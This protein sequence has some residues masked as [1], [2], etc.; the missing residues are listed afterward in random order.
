MSAKTPFWWGILRLSKQQS[1]EQ[2]GISEMNVTSTRAVIVEAGGTQVVGHVG[3][4]AL[5]AFADRVGV[6]E[7]LSVAVGWDGP[8]IP[9]HDRGRVLSQ[10]MLMLAGGGESCADIEALASQG[11]LF[12]DVCS[13]TTLYRTFPRALDEAALV[14]A[15]RAMAQVRT[16][17]WRRT[18]AT[19]GDGPVILDID[20]S[21]VEI[22]SE[23][24]EGAA[25]HFK[26]GYGFHPVFCFAD[27]T[28]DVLAGHLR[29][30][31]AAA[32]DTSDLLAVV[33]DGVDQLPTDVAAGHRPGD[34]PGL[35]QRQVVVRSD[36]A[37]GT[38]VFVEG[39]RGRNI[40][41]AVVARRQ[42]AV[43]AAIMIANSD[44]QRWEA[45]LKQNG[46]QTDTTSDGR[47][48][49]VCEVTD[50]VD[51]GGW[52]DG[53]RLIIRRQP[54]HPGAQTTLL[55]DLEY[56]FWGHYTDQAGDPVD[57]DRQMRAHARVEDHIQRLKDSGLE[58]FPFTEWAPNQ[59]WLQ[60]VCWAADLVR[61]FQLLC[62][63]GPLTRARPKRLRWTL[64]HAPARIITTARRDIVRILDGWPTAGDIV[65]AYRN[66]AALT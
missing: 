19:D 53:T 62:L 55:P 46:E 12:G 16:Q 28:G 5:G 9:V 38:K 52:P 66:I 22:H 56:R 35:V 39:L 34:D 18:S 10:A 63:T 42:A 32:N 20:A 48:A 3:L 2:K 26:G 13:D 58:R 61:W 60:T 1:R 11:R 24:K 6:T 29:A 59:A 50:L 45:A 4:H 8:G 7:S 47:T 21:L 37:G 49:A 36:S 57:L 30:G 25:A 40:G 41:F 14:R 17:V 33:D 54:L 44:S 51:L 15:R 64:W 43:S 31:N 27:G 65:A 23:N